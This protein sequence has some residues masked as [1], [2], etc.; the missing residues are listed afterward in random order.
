MKYL[1]KLLVI[2]YGYHRAGRIV[3]HQL[4]DVEEQQS[5]PK[6]PEIPSNTSTFCPEG[7]DWCDDPLQYP[8]NTILKAVSKQKKAIR[9]MFD[10]EKLPEEEVNE[11]DIRLRIFDPQFENI[12]DVETTYIKPRAAKNKEGK[13]MFIVNHPEGADESSS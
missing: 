5:N 9:I 6:V 8:E 11:I 10:E 3:F 4:K 12:C 1:I 13:F 7:L 2:H